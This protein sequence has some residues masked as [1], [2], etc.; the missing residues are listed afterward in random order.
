[1]RS[2]RGGLLQFLMVVAILAGGAVLVALLD[3][4][5]G[6]LAGQAHVS[7]GDTISINGQRVRIVGI[8]APELDQTCT[9]KAGSAW[10]CGREAREHLVALIGKAPVTCASEGRDK[11]GRVLGRCEAGGADLGA[12]MIE[13]GFAVSYDDY[14]V[15]ETLARIDR[16]GIWAGSF[17]TPQK[18]RKDK[19]AEEPAFDLRGW[20]LSWLGN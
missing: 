16:R 10:R 3:R 13:A 4:S 18:W 6:G 7:D 5:G 20:L 9:D 15:R 14:K 1:M 8:D 2:R 19:G 12:A 11:Y 17:E